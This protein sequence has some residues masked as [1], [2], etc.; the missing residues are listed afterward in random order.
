V[1]TAAF[2]LAA[3]ADEGLQAEEPAPIGRR[4]R[5]GLQLTKGSAFNLQVLDAR[6]EGVFFRGQSVEGIKETTDRDTLVAA[7]M[8]VDRVLPASMRN[9]LG[10]AAP[11]LSH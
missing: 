11:R 5:Q 2:L 9:P 6:R 4:Q 7:L 3:V 8:P 10:G 1:F